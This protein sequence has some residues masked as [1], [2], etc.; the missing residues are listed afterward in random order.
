MN[1]Q[2]HTIVERE[3]RAVNRSGRH[4]IVD[5]VPW[6]LFSVDYRHDGSSYQIDIWSP[7]WEDAERRVRSIRGNANLD[8][9]VISRYHVP[10][11]ATRIVEPFLNFY[12]WFR[13][14]FVP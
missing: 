13:N 9:Q 10:S 1:Y 14:L 8:A 7:S 4:V 12:I 5:G 11:W 2:S 6:Y 3:A